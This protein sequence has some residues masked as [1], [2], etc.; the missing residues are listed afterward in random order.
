MNNVAKLTTDF[1]RRS[2]EAWQSDQGARKQSRWQ[3][4]LERR[5]AREE[6][7]AYDRQQADLKRAYKTEVTAAKRAD[8][9]AR[10]Q[11]RGYTVDFKRVAMS[12]AAE[13]VIASASGYG[14]Y[15]FALKYGTDWLTTQQM[16]LAPIAYATVEL[17]RVPLAL[18]VR[19]H[20]QWLVRT[21]AL[22]GVL[23]A[24]AITVKSMS[25]LGNM[26]FSPRLA[27][28]VIAR[29]KL[30]LAQATDDQIGQRIA[31]ADK[32][33]EQRRAEQR[34]AAEKE[35]A[36]SSQL[37]SLPPPA[38]H[39]VSWYDRRAN[40]V[41]KSTV[42]TPDARGAPLTSSLSAAQSATKNAQTAH[43]SAL[44]ARSALDRSAADKA[45]ADAHTTYREAVRN[46]QLHDFASM[47]WGISPSEV[48]DGMIAQFLRWFVFG[49]AVCVAF[50]STM[51]AFTAITRVKAPKPSTVSVHDRHLEFV[52]ESLAKKII[53]D[54]EEA[55]TTDAE[56]KIARNRQG[57]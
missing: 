5:A 52:L 12:Y 19:T 25:Q 47:V 49:A 8:K 26:M 30:D 21:V 3:R 56:A 34:S 31:V 27:D 33:V 18:S 46:S 28:V 41:V 4:R 29:E 54:A 57:G 6:V 13:G 22:V 17:C 24:A 38:C 35:Q 50:A 39:P 20:R 45:L 15:L 44:N 48:T 1:G 2:E 36:T 51:I 53:A 9:I 23:G 11:Q 10:D 32:L 16:I 7:A 42:C 37:V 43:E 14:Q 40:A 55:V